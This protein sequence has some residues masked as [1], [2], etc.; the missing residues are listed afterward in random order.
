M[1]RSQF[2]DVEGLF[3]DKDYGD[4]RMESLFNATSI[5]MPHDLE[6]LSPVYRDCQNQGT[7]ELPQ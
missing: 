2:N 7:Y 6:K 3:K 4:C 5:Q 1:P